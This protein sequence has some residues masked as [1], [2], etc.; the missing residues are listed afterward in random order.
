MDFVDRDVERGLLEELLRSPEAQF[1]RI[2][3]RRRVG[4]TALIQEVLQRR[5]HLYLVADPGETSSQ[6]RALWSQAAR[7]LR[8]PMPVDP[9]WEGFLDELERIGRGVVVIDEFQ[10]LIERDLHLAGQIQRRWEASWSRT[11]PSLVIAGSSIGMMQSLTRYR[12][13]PFYGRLTQDLHLRPFGYAG[14]RLL[15]PRLSEAEK[16]VRFAV[17]GGTPYYHQRSVGRSLEQA[18]QETVLT[19]GAPL[20]EEPLHLLATETRE[21][22]RYHAILNGIAHGA[23]TLRDLE[24]VLHVRPGG[25]GSYLRTLQSDL[26]LTGVE[27]PVC[28]L[29]KRA[30]YVILDPFF[31][32]YYRFVTPIRSEIETGRGLEAWEA[33][34]VD[35]NAYVGRVFEDVIRE[36]LLVNASR[37]GPL[38]TP[39]FREAGRWWNRSGEEIDVVARS[40]SEVWAGEVYWT[41]D[42]VREED[43][44]RLRQKATLMERTAHL[45]VRL[46]VVSRGPVTDGAKHRLEEEGGLT[47]SIAD[48][49]RMFGEPSPG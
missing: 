35:F 12:T 42:S 45:P 3:G 1:I 34:K 36:A 30:H 14:T 23:H 2:S 38:K 26:D 31:R 25:L 44:R 27:S 46:F 21:P 16:V 47:M 28:G 22:S 7:S 48:V 9:S 33:G 43:V 15:Y 41:V 39:R 49:G 40:D 10:Y 17:F 37:R 32:F 4:K 8:R 11:G 6:L 18:L 24:G 5:K 20:V 29:G 19:P 13:G